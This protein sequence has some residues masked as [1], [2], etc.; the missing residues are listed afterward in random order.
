MDTV[1]LSLLGSRLAELRDRIRLRSHL[2][3]GNRGFMFYACTALS[4]EPF[5]SRQRG[6]A[7]ITEFHVIS[8]FQR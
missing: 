4:T 2:R 7:V 5:S 6:A 3:L 8:I 1:H